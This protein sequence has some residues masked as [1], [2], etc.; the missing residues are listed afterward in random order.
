MVSVDVEQHLK[1]K[2]IEVDLGSCV[3]VEVDVLGFPVPN[4][5]PCCLST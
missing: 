2:S 4:N 5:S 1:K 3:E